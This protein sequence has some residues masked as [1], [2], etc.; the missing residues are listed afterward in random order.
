M[1]TQTI[2]VSGLSNREFIER[3]AQPGRV[4]LCGGTTKVDLAIRHAQRHLHAER[5]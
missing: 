1:E 2:V 4:G 3:H 5:R